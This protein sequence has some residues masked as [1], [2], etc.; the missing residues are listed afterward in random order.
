M[1]P[2]DYAQPGRLTEALE[3]L[4]GADGR[5]VRPLAGGTD[6]LPMM[7]GDLIAPRQ[8]VDL[9]RLVDLDGRIEV[10]ASGLEIG[11]LATLRELERHQVVGSAAP[12]LAE[13][14]AVA[15]S[16]Q[17]RNMATL[18]GNLLQ[19]PRCWYFRN[20]AIDCWLKG[21]AECPA[22]PGEN[23]LHALFS[24][25][26]C[27]AAHPSDLATALVA[28]DAR[29]RVVGPGGERTIPLESFFAHPTDE[30]RRENV[31]GED[32]IIRTVMIPQGPDLADGDGAVT[33]STYRK[34]MDRKVWAFALVGV[35]V[36][37]T[38]AAGRIA[39][40]RVVLGGVSQVP[41]RAHGAEALLAGEEP[42]DG[43]FREA[44]EA[45][46]AGADPLE[47]NGYKIPLAKSLVRRALEAVTGVGV[48]G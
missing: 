40:A 44:A 32:E 48:A 6:L 3:L 13:A 45:A 21:G 30:R 42:S 39:E 35:G 37:A 10:D 12:A 25:G 36:R 20:A 22:R 2:F 9:K 31:L 17:L 26:P 14:A 47:H 23:G 41:W 4:A 11:A 29:V 46:L 5:Q 27:V 28:L 8:V 33:V 38:M 16:P 43:L 7:K 15:A 34:A 19:R 24:P 18:G 1:R